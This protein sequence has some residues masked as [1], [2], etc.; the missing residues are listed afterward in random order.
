MRIMQ[1]HT[2]TRAP[3]ATRHAHSHTLQSCHLLNNFNSRP[4]VGNVFRTRTH[5]QAAAAGIKI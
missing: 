2:H 4:Q 1:A 5:T 3:H